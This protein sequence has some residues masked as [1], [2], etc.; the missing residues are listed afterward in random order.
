[1]SPQAKLVL[2]HLKL[3]GSIS[4][5]EANAVLRVRSVS[6]R[7][8]EIRD[9]GYIID[10]E[11]KTDST[12]QRYVRYVFSPRNTAP[13]TPAVTNPVIDFART[14]FRNARAVTA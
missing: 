3:V 14:L 6:R 10:K 1:M 8:T 5:V 7:I 13:Y 2:A 12:G 9:A 4:N 11:H